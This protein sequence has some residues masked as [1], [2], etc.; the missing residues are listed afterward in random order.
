MEWCIARG[1]RNA[2]ERL[3]YPLNVIHDDSHFNGETQVEIGIDPCRILCLDARNL[4][5][6][7]DRLF[8]ECFEWFLH[9]NSSRSIPIQSGTLIEARKDCTVY[10]GQQSRNS[11]HFLPDVDQ[12]RANGNVP[13]HEFLIFLIHRSHSVERVNMGNGPARTDY[14]LLEKLRYAIALCIIWVASDL[15]GVLC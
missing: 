14:E 8:L 11:I 5:F 15:Q 13:L 6:C 3:P 12:L 9:A 1:L 7:K 2:S 4:R 10:C